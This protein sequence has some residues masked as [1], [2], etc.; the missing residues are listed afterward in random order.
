M[1]T[2][3]E[4]LG[5]LT[6]REVL[7]QSCGQLTE[8]PK[9]PFVSSGSEHDELSRNVEVETM[10]AHLFTPAGDES[11]NAGSFGALSVQP[12]AQRWAQEDAANTSGPPYFV[13]KG[14]TS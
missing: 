14:R 1:S 11:F 4:R 2:W 6:S 12:L 10:R 9:A 8:L 5:E 3:R 13:L 7:E